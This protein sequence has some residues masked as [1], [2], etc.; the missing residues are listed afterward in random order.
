[1]SERSFKSYKTESTITRMYLNSKSKFQESCSDQRWYHPINNLICRAE[2][3]V[4]AGTILL[5]KKFSTLIASFLED[6]PTMV[7][8]LLK[9]TQVIQRLPIVRISGHYLETQ[10]KKLYK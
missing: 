6:R 8:F 2:Q 3:L 4:F 9:F 10:L 1:M 7:L 5:N